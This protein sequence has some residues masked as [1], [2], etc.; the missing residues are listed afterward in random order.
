MKR[1]LRLIGLAAIAIPLTLLLAGYLYQLMGSAR[2]LQQLRAGSEFHRVNGRS[3]FIRC[4][5]QRAPTIV[6]EAGAGSWSAHWRHIQDELA[7]SA[8]V[9]SYDRAGLGL[10]E[11]PQSTLSGQDYVR[12]LHGLLELAG[13]Q[14]PY[15][16]VGHSMGG[17]LIRLYASL[18]PDEVAGLVLADAAHE[19]QWTE[20]PPSVSEL[21]EA[22]LGQMGMATWMARFGLMRLS[23]LP[24]QGFASEQQEAHIQAVMMTTD[25]WPALGAE[26]AAGMQALPD[27]VRTTPDLGDLPLLVISAGRSADTYCATDGSAGIDCADA[28]A[29]W[30]RLQV[31]LTR[32]SSN[33]RQHILPQ[34]SHAIYT[35]NPA[36]VVREIRDF[37]LAVR[38]GRSQRN[39]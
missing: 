36:A 33:S 13:E 24:P 9:C 11:A 19:D 15:I 14:P 38:S 10:S 35:D 5:G 27:A 3:L 18:Y 28:Q 1:A 4:I 23:G 12:D 31:E 34:A 6:F 37:T 17:Y 32:L 7:D 8:R 20:F 26:F 2:D 25:Y 21:M 22:T 30:D 39:D 29:V 16:L